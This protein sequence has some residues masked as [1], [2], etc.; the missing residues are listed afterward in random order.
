MRDALDAHCL[1]RRLGIAG[2]EHAPKVLAARKEEELVRGHRLSLHLEQDVRELT[3]LHHALEVT[4]ERLRRRASVRLEGPLEA[5]AKVVPPVVTPKD[6]ER[7]AVHHADVRAARR[8]R[9]RA[10]PHRLPHTRGEVEAAEVVEGRAARLASEG[11]DAV[12][13]HDG[14]VASPR[15]RGHACGVQGGLDDSS[16]TTQPGL[17]KR[18]RAA[19]RSCGRET[20]RS[21]AGPC[22]RGRSASG[23][24]HTRQRRTAR[25]SPRARRSTGQ[26]ARLAPSLR[27]APAPTRRSA[28]RRRACR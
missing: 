3:A 2:G 8:G 23:R 17:Q 28:R 7:A 25:S 16:L 6:E 21:S 20:T 13:M 1:C 12:A 19:C 4:R 11:V 15:R 5:V 9:G 24:H 18:R 26:S 10:C 14:G 22:E 27:P